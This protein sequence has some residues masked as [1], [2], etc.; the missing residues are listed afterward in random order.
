[1]Q[2][3]G[4]RTFRSISIDGQE[5]EFSEGFTDL[6]TESYRGIL[7]GEGFGLQDA[8]PSIA[9]VH[10]IRE[11]EVRGLSGEYHPLAALPQAKHPFK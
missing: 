1:V 5:L 7:A 9:L 8:A 11:A 2:E 6:H 4:G 10:E 3:K